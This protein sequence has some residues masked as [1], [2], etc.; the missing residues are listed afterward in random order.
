MKILSM[1]N[2]LPKKLEKNTVIE[3]SLDLRCN[4]SQPIEVVAVSLLNN[5]SDKALNGLER[6]PTM[7]IPEVV[8]NNDPNL[9]NAPLYQISTERMVLQISKYGV[10]Y[11]N[12]SPYPGWPVFEGGLNEFLNF[13]ISS[14][15]VSFVERIGLRYINFLHADAAQVCKISF[16]SGIGLDRIQFNHVD[17]FRK[18][19]F[20]I[21]TVIANEAKLNNVI[22][23]SVLDIDVSCSD[24]FEP[25]YDNFASRIEEMHSI[26]RQTYFSSLSN[27]FLEDLGP[28]YE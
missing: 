8:R 2:Q 17:V 26:C 11:V 14:K 9:K 18:D 4:F 5:Y 21:K 23:G 19:H 7:D 12:K 28:S 13:I 3:S 25:L 24:S 20:I 22:R 16:N 27:D 6:L 10:R 1:H 15:T